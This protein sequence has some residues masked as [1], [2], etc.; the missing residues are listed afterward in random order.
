MASPT[1][2]AKH[3]GCTGGPQSA[4]TTYHARHLRCGVGF[5]MGCKAGP[6]FFFL[7]SASDARGETVRD[8]FQIGLHIR[9]RLSEVFLRIQAWHPTARGGGTVTQTHTQ[10][11]TD[12]CKERKRGLISGEER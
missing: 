2:R 5:G 12:K 11:N 7:A 9:Q 6:F 10:T 8:L 4:W 1:R 3:C